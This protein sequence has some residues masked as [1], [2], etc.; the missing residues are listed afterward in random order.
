MRGQGSESLTSLL[1]YKSKSASSVLFR[2]G[3]NRAGVVESGF[4]NM[5]ANFG[6]ER[7]Y[8]RNTQ[9]SAILCA[10]CQSRSLRSLG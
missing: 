7:V 9:K 10:K 6:N 8:G 4:A 2:G 5:S 3:D 1:R